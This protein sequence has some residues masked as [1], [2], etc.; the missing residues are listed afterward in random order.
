MRAIKSVVNTISKLKEQQCETEDKQLLLKALRDV[1][2]PKFVKDDRC[3]LWDIVIN[4]FPGDF[5]PDYNNIMLKN[6]I[7]QVAKG[8]NLEA[9]PAF[10]EKILQL[11]NTI[12][13]RHAN[14]LIGPA[15]SGKSTIIRTLAKTLSNLPDESKVNIHTLNPK[16]V[17][18]EELYGYYDQN[19]EWKDGVITKIMKKC[20][21]D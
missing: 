13:I 6:G 14:M 19:N 5:L 4:I 3:T 2:L 16:A 10:I 9:N 21:Q 18:C 8:D 7:S 12:N 17:A 15:A 20:V 11:D 1:V